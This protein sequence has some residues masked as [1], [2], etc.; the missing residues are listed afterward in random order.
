MAKAQDRGLAAGIEVNSRRAASIT[1]EITQ[2]R[3]QWRQ[4]SA[5]EGLL[6][7]EVQALGIEPEAVP[8]RTVREIAAARETWRDHPATDAQIRKLEELSREVDTP[9]D[10][11]P[12]ITKGQAHDAISGILSGTITQV[13]FR[14]RPAGPMFIEAAEPRREAT[15]PEIESAGAEPPVLTPRPV[16]DPVAEVERR[17]ME[18]LAA[19]DPDADAAVGA[20]ANT[21][22]QFLDWATGHFK[23]K[24]Q[25]ALADLM[26]ERDTLT[27]EMFVVCRTILADPKRWSEFGHRAAEA[28]WEA[29]RDEPIQ[30]PTTTAV[31]D[32]IVE[33]R[34]SEDRAVDQGY[35]DTAQ[36]VLADVV[37]EGASPE[38]RAEQVEAI[39]DAL[40]FGAGPELDDW[41]ARG[42]AAFDAATP[43][44]LP[45]P[46][47]DPGL[48]AALGKLRSRR[49]RE[50]LT[51]Q[52]FAGAR[53]GQREATA[54]DRA[55]LLTEAAHDPRVIAEVGGRTTDYLPSF[56]PHTTA[57]RNVVTELAR[58]GSPLRQAAAQLILREHD[59]PTEFYEAS[60]SEWQRAHGHEL[61][62]DETTG[63]SGHRGCGCSCAAIR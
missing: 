55:A 26:S 14:D 38:E 32:A 61:T 19:Q 35:L 23:V 34:A 53:Q 59:L 15:Q 27:D 52:W 3:A 2:L 30:H 40:D 4:L 48:A 56:Q 7:N 28:Y 47:T 39:Q 62:W 50:E 22:D 9:F 13:Q 54:D 25:V 43:M 63:R 57:T 58:G 1:S 49:A 60:H 24:A 21:A 46:E 20:Q 8:K 41:W 45:T 16:V 31:T 11:D 18:R 36:G 17:L 5:R 44:D 37:A 29:H 6:R 51:N 33:A 12:N 42:R 10:V